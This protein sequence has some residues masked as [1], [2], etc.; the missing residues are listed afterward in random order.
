MGT[1]ILKI[2]DVT[3]VNPAHDLHWLYHYLPLLT[4]LTLF[5]IVPQ[6]SRPSLPQT[7]TL[8]FTSEVT[9]KIKGKWEEEPHIL[10]LLYS[11]T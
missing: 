9:M 4:I 7:S 11:T 2:P 1:I 3:A 6:A 8:P 10:K 5:T